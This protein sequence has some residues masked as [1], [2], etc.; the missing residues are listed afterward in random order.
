MGAGSARGRRDSLICRRPRDAEDRSGAAFAAH[1]LPLRESRVK[2]C[3]DRV[4][5][6]SMRKAGEVGDRC[7]WPDAAQRASERRA[8]VG[9]LVPRGSCV[10]GGGGGSL[11]GRG[12]PAPR[13]APLR[14]SCVIRVGEGWFAVAETCDRAADGG[15]VLAGHAP[16]E[17]MRAGSASGCRCASSACRA[18]TVPCVQRSSARVP[19]RGVSPGVFCGQGVNG[20]FDPAGRRP[21]RAVRKP[22]YRACGAVWR[23][24]PR[25]P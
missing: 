24:S 3:G 23:R 20:V 21:L 6:V 16:C 7:P 9:R 25:R 8:V 1:K 15:L 2:A 5:R 11:A 4:P 17:P 14:S 13:S 22:G 18:R 10:P 19:R 12:E